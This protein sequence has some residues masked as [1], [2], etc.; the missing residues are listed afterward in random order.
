MTSLAPGGLAIDDLR[1][2]SVIVRKASENSPIRQ[3]RYWLADV[4]DAYDS[5]VA[6]YDESVESDPDLP[7]AIELAGSLTP[8]MKVMVAGIGA[9]K[10]TR[11]LRRDGDWSLHLV[12]TDPWQLDFTG[13]KRDHYENLAAMA[14]TPCVVWG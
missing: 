14:A 3:M 11:V 13:R 9:M 1:R 7:L 8:G 10:L 2:Q 4:A 6:T 5:A 12:I